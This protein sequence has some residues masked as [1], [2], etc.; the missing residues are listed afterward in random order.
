MNKQEQE[1]FLRHAEDQLEIANSPYRSIIE[2]FGFVNDQYLDLKKVHE[3]EGRGLSP[4]EVAG[5]LDEISYWKREIAVL[6]R[7]I[8]EGPVDG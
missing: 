8:L 5:L 4:D 7:R 2:L 3:I 6:S 1:R